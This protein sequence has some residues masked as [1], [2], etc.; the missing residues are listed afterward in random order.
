MGEVGEHQEVHDVVVPKFSREYKHALVSEEE[1]VLT[2]RP[3]E[4]GTQTF[5]VTTDKTP[6]GKW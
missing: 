4:R 5:F 2:L 3:E 6:E 1:E